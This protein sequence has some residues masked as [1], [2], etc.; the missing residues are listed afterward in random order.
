[1]RPRQ[2]GS[3]HLLPGVWSEAFSA[4]GGANASARSASGRARRPVAACRYGP[5]TN[6]CHP[7]ADAPAA[8]PSGSSD[9]LRL[10]CRSS[11]RTS[12]RTGPGWLSQLRER[13]S[14]E[15]PLLRCVRIPHHHG[16]SDG[17]R[18]APSCRCSRSAN[19]RPRANRN[20]GPQRHGGHGGLL[21][22]RIRGAGTRR[23]GRY[24]HRTSTGS[25][26][27][28]AGSRDDAAVLSTLP[29]P[30]GRERTVLQAVRLTARRAD[31][32]A[33]PGDPCQSFRSL[34]RIGSTSDP[35]CRSQAPVTGVAR[36]GSNGF[37][38]ARHRPERSTCP[39]RARRQRGAHSPGWRSDRHRPDRRHRT[40]ERGSVRLAASR[41]HCLPYRFLLPPGP[42]KHEW[43]LLSHPL[44]R[45]SRIRPGT[46][47]RKRQ[48]KVERFRAAS[49][50][51]RLVLGGTTGAK[52]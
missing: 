49:R 18:D 29:R 1:M 28:R 8:A 40:T 43:R 34:F 20:G 10:P 19:I 9:Q 2:S 15:R 24:C 4:R 7:T 12:G 30:V 14:T 32:D 3:P 48:G 21:G 50:G 5:S 37:D 31:R 16:H 35:V 33:P 47:R 46:R 11:S 38:G 26:V 42:R 52:V 25:G 6:R 13:Q 39:R 27:R 44:S 22:P 41:S 17:P 45:R 51:S 36:T 23:F